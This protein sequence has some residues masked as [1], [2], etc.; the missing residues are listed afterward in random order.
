MSRIK[1]IWWLLCASC[2]RP[3][4]SRIRIY[5]EVLNSKALSPPN[6]HTTAILN[7]AVL[8]QRLSFL[9]LS[10]C[11]VAV[12]VLPGWLCL[13]LIFGDDLGA[14][15]QQRRREIQAQQYRDCRRQ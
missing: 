8:I 14:Q 9:A 10:C 3:T 2:N 11:A 7:M 1:K 12:A 6:P 4:H 15:Q 5:E 13:A